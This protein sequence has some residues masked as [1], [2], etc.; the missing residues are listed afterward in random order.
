MFESKKTDIFT[1]VKELSYF[2]ASRIATGIFE[3]LAPSWLITIGINQT[4]FDIDGF[5]AKLIVSI[6][7]VI[8]NYIL[9]KTIVFRKKDVCTK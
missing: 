4:L 6:I 5:F 2:L 9:S 3:I 7:V 1:V 8:L